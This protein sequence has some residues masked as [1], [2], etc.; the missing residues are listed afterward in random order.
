MEKENE[1]QYLEILMELFR[2]RRVTMLARREKEKSVQKMYEK[3]M[4]FTRQQQAEL[5]QL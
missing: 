1:L 3:Y 5:Q 4:T 2:Q